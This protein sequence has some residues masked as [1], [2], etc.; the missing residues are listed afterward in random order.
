[1]TLG[2][3]GRRA[4][5]AAVVVWTAA[6][7]VAARSARR[8]RR[9]PDAPT[10]HTLIVIQNMPLATDRRVQTEALA[11]REQGWR[12]SVICPRADDEPA[13]FDLNG[14]EVY[15]YPPPP[16]TEG[17]LSFVVEFIYAWLQAARLSLIV[18]GRQ[19]FQ[20]LQACNPP[21]TYWLLA[22]LWR[23]AGV[24]FVF[25]QH[26]LCP[27]LYE[28]R[29]RERDLLYR[30]LLALERASYAVADHVLAPNLSYRD[31]ALQRGGVAD[32]RVS[33]VMSS[34]DPT[35]MRRGVERPEL[36]GGARHLVCY[37][38]IMGPQDGV[39][40]L[41]SAAHR[42]VHVHGRNDVRFALLGYGDSM[43][44]LQRQAAELD[45]TREVVFTGRVD[46]TEIHRWL[47]TGDVGVTPDPKSDF[48]DRSTMNKTLEYMA[49]QMPVV[50]TDL[51]ETRRTA[52][53][54]AV[55]VDTEE[56]MA[57]AILGLL[58]DPQ[59]RTAMGEEG[60][61]RIEA[62]LAW[63]H[64]RSRLLQAYDRLVPPG[65]RQPSAP[66]Q[67]EEVVR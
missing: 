18:S 4:A 57:Q 37:V 13:R 65:A 34:P 20:V 25:D 47:S 46:H 33:V 52:G 49:Y 21:D 17:V 50:A 29:F 60:R 53:A 8:A 48:N 51:M 55:Y 56:E 16:P 23:P 39:D 66:K 35:V 41:L 15:A 54:A 45:L 7:L 26:D 32:D 40:R 59:R 22:L 38:G 64:Q 27:E 30:L 10:R 62:Q 28:A 44:S 3:A 42:I 43:A 36:R 1:M 31:V 63:H 19:S 6:V 58:A 24:R 12:V 5:V 11:L 2:G 67:A 61:R 9:C 14:V